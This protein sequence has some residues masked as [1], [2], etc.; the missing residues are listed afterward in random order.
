MGRICIKD[1]P[2]LG[3]SKECSTGCCSLPALSRVGLCP[4]LIRSLVF[5]SSL[6]TAAAGDFL[7]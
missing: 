3:D 7:L 5:L 2:E 4:F 1:Y 6:A